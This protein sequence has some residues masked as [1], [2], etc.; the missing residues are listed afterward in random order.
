MKG[1]AKGS[2]EVTTK[3]EPVSDMAGPAG[4]ARMSLDKSFSGDLLG[5][6]VG[7][8]LSTMG[9]EQGS[10]GYVAIERFRGRIG[11]RSG[12]FALLHK[13]LMNR[14]TPTLQVVVVPDSGKDGFVG[15]EGVM[16]IDIADGKHHYTLTYLLPD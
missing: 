16:S 14:G 3:S 2:F 15:I 12:S 5:T 8:M 10:A 4:I 11:S 13:G 9:S 7:E 6:S 1:V